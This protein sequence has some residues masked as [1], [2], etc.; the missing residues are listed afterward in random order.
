MSLLQL[1]RLKPISIVQLNLQKKSTPNGVLGETYLD[2][3]RLYK[4]KNKTE[5]ARGCLSKAIKIFEQN[6][7]ELLLE[8]AKEVL[9][10]LG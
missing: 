3:G 4:I 1:K 7:A 10:S 8:Q 9:E 5:Q 6:K 2:L